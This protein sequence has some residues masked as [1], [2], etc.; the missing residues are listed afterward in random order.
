[1]STKE[2]VTKIKLDSVD[3]K[4][5]MEDTKT[6]VLAFSGIVTGAGVALA[7]MT[8]TSAEQI[9]AAS[10]MARSAGTTTEA[11]SALAYSAKLADIDT[12]TLA[13]GLGKMTT[14]KAR[15]EIQ[16]LGIAL[17]D[18]SGA[19]RTQEQILN[20]LADRIQQT[21]NPIEK[22]RIAMDV[23]GKSGGQFVTLLNDGSEGL[24]ALKSEAESFGQIFTDEAG[25]SA[26]EFNDNLTRLD[27]VIGGVK[28]T[29]SQSIIQF[30]LQSNVVQSITSAIKSG[31]QWWKSLDESTK[32]MIV[33][34]AALTVGLAAI[35]A[36]I[37][38]ITMILPTVSAAFTAAF[39]TNPIGLV[40]VA[41]AAVAAGIYAITQASPEAKSALESVW[42]ILKTEA[43]RG[44]STYKQIFIDPYVNAYNFLRDAVNL[45]STHLGALKTT[46]QTVVQPIVNIASGI[47]T[48]VKNT[49]TNI[50]GSLESGI[51]NF[52]SDV[53]GGEVNTF[54]TKVKD[55]TSMKFEFPDM[56]RLFLEK[57]VNPVRAGMYAVKNIIVVAF[58]QAWS[59]SAR[60][61]GDIVSN[62]AEKIKESFRAA[63]DT[64][65]N[66]SIKDIWAGTGDQLMASVTVTARNIGNKI[67]SEMQRGINEGAA[68]GRA[69]LKQYDDELARRSAAGSAVAAE[70]KSDVSPP[71]SSGP[72]SGG[73]QQ[74][75][76]F[77]GIN[78]GYI[79]I[80]QNIE[81]LNE[82]LSKS[83]SLVEKFS[84]GIEIA[85]SVAQGIANE[86]TK[87]F[88]SQQALA[89]QQL[90]NLKQST[91]F[92]LQGLEFLIDQTLAAQ[93][94][95]SDAALA[96]I[97]AQQDAL[98]A[99]EQEYQDRIQAIKDR[100]S[101]ERKAQIDEELKSQ[102]EHLHELYEAQVQA[103]ED[104][105]LKGV[106]LEAEKQEA[107]ARLEAE[108][109]QL[110]AQSKEKLSNDIK[111]ND[112]KL[113]A[114]QDKHA[115]DQQK[116][117]A[118][119][120][121]QAKSIQDKQKAD[122]DAAAAQKK[123]L[124][125]DVKLFEW[126]AGRGAFEMGKKAQIAQAG[127]GIAMGV[128][129]A[130][131]AG[132][133]IAATVPV[134][135]WIVGPAFAATL[136]T[137]VATAGANAIRT[138]ASMQYPPPPV[139]DDGGI[140]YGPARGSGWS[141]IDPEL[142]IPISN[143]GKDFG[144]LK[145]SVAKALVGRTSNREIAP[146]I[147][148]YFEARDDYETIKNKL[149]TDLRDMIRSAIAS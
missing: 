3:F 31:I 78:N 90:A 68:E 62:L 120:A 56:A 118:E 69:T 22:T 55:I 72:V 71:S 43:Q 91:D 130:I 113:A 94:R 51:K 76:M 29:I 133:M 45:V 79:S 119:L 96:A 149:N 102:F 124:E 52:I 125:R 66:V 16:K 86:F 139:F 77:Q 92:Q 13:K 101:D 18:S 49:V 132:A 146:Q 145:D 80:I 110:I 27:L 131:Q 87:V 15:A 103:L 6:A 36:G 106:E 11:F 44:V 99:Q 38:G 84:Y 17:T 28:N 75:K 58:P 74:E 26:E 126:S 59:E 9:D 70:R 63:L 33:G 147:N 114:E 117:Q 41:L 97:K 2:L 137:M 46:M 89:N 19:A 140:S 98:V 111:K 10:K 136:S 34:A 35:T 20:D 105:G 134:V 47:A 141:S 48:S 65:S 60:L 37:I 129:N 93:K 14:D 67:S 25:K 121:A 138:A 127:V 40:I 95:E 128:M 64:N 123:E 54:I 4:R 53:T 50:V 32:N 5:S 57:I 148:N 107:L 135:G 144:A 104:S 112:D 61:V 24:A 21:A 142:H 109:N 30:V 122:E 23:F 143:P 81:N 39:V 7:M 115:K 12:E 42:D 108:K 85:K 116:Q 1:M 82:K 73:P 88:Q 8:K 100:Y 83:T